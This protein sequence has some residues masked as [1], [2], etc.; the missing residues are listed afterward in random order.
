A[1]TATKTSRPCRWSQ[2]PRYLRRDALSRGRPRPGPRRESHLP[3]RHEVRRHPRVMRKDEPAE[4][5][6]TWPEVRFGYLQSAQGR[7]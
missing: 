5:C 3:S 6:L 7:P 4:L 1:R 2:K